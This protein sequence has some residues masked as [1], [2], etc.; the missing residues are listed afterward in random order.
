MM[1]GVLEN[2]VR[3]R[4]ASLNR[5]SGATAQD[6]EGFLFYARDICHYVGLLS[7]MWQLMM[8][9]LHRAGGPAKIFG[10]ECNRLA[11]LISVHEQRLS[12][13][14]QTWKSRAIP[15]EIAQTVYPEIQEAQRQLAQLAQA[16]HRFHTQVI[17][18]IVSSISP[19]KLKQLTEKAKQAEGWMPLKEAIAAMRQS[20]T[21]N[22]G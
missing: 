21:Q 18:P 11:E 2:M 13:V 3:E 6:D 22:Q 5:E 20:T 9:R 8:E 19:E 7:L 17:Q 4:A 16:V 15:E 14:A 12:A 10:D 1:T